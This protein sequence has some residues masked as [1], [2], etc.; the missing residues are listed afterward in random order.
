MSIG[1]IKRSGIANTIGLPREGRGRCL[2][3]TDNQAFA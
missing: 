1:L 3:A 2:R